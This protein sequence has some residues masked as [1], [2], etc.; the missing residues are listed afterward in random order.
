MPIES[1]LFV[2]TVRWFSVFLCLPVDSGKDNQDVHEIAQPMKP[3]N[4]RRKLARYGVGSL[5]ASLHR[6]RLL[7]LLSDQVDVSPI[8]FNAT[9]LAFRHSQ[10]LSPG[11]PVVFDLAK[12]QHAVSSVVGIVRYITRMENH[13]RCGVEFDFDASEHMRS[14]QTRETLTAIEKLLREVVMPAAG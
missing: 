5:R 11:Q 3:K 14:Q 1:R 10:L 13:Y 12:D 9:G 4:T 6:T 7:G 8:D 2:E